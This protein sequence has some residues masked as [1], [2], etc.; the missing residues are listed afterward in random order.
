MIP[1]FQSAHFLDKLLD[2]WNYI[3][4]TSLSCEMSI[5]CNTCGRVDW[6]LR[7]FL[8]FYHAGQRL[9]TVLP[10]GLVLRLLSYGRVGDVMFIFTEILMVWH[11]LIS[12]A[13]WH[14]SRTY[15]WITFCVQLVHLLLGPS[16]LL[17]IEEGGILA[18]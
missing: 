6:R 11:T 7:K 13:A 3:A 17:T 12:F 18:M 10:P 9:S 16:I 1:G 8:F 2:S 5:F 4:A 14:N 15:P